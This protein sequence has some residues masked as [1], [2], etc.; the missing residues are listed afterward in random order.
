MELAFALDRADRYAEAAAEYTRFL[1]FEPGFA[2][3]HFGRAM[4]LLLDDR[5]ATARRSLGKSLR[6]LP[7]DLRLRHLLARV[8]ATCPA[9]EGRDGNRALEL[10]SQVLREQETLEH[11]ESLAMAYAEL[12]RFD[13]AAESPATTMEWPVATAA[14]A[15]GAL[16]AWRA[17][18]GA[19]ERRR[20]RHLAEDSG[21]L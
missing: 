9:A 11:T 16:Q 13:E 3:A 6:S 14:P 17:M 21:S 19:V 5:S 10:G 2:E 4:A 7:G 20:S 15:A 12:G 8:L 1:E 18:P